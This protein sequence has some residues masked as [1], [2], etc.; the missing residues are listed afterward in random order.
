MNE[1]GPSRR[2]RLGVALL[3]GLAMGAVS[4]LVSALS[5]PS[6]ASDFDPVHAGARALLAGRDP[7]AL[8][9]AER[10]NPFGLFYPVP[11]LLAALP[12]AWLPLAAARAAFAGLTSALYAFA[13]T[14]D[15]WTRWPALV[16]MALVQNAILCQW[17]ALLVGAMLTPALAGL[18]LT[19]PNIGAALGLAGVTDPAA[20][21]GRR[22]LPTAALSVFAVV[23]VAFTIRPDWIGAWLG[24]LRDTRHVTAPIA[25]GSGLG[26]LLLLAALR[27]RRPEARLLLT[28]SLVPATP[29][30]V[31]GLPLFLVC[32][33]P[34]EAAWF[35]VLTYVEYIAVGAAWAAGWS[36]PSGPGVTY[37]SAGAVMSL[38]L[39]YL[40]CLVMVLRRPNEAPEGRDEKLRRPVARNGGRQGNVLAR[41]E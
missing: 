4:A 31:E 26:L 5:A 9:A 6:W 2:A 36:A 1:A 39:L 18:L 16:S 22:H 32:R 15:G 11:A 38:A 19:K 7:Y 33:T 24:A 34:R 37:V 14:R 28:L 12:V 10:R 21:G 35:A 17:S 23:L 29:S 8:S 20:L 40:P 30:A 25:R 41:G 27:W 13:V 3:T